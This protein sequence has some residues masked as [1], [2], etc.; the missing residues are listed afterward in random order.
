MWSFLETQCLSNSSFTGNKI[1]RHEMLK[2]IFKVQMLSSNTLDLFSISY[3]ISLKLCSSY[4]KL[5]NNSCKRL[6]KISQVENNVVLNDL[7][8]VYFFLPKSF[9]L[10]YNN[11]IEV[12]VNV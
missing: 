2:Q 3:N 7:T 1:F 5:L 6:K 12:C 10:F 11:Y 8:S 4:R 9:Q